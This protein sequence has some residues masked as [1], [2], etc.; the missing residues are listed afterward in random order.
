MDRIKFYFYYLDSQFEGFAPIIRITVFVVMLLLFLYLLS[1][2]RLFLI[3]R[4]ISKRRRRRK[5]IRNKYENGIRDVICSRVNLDA[6]DISN[7]IN[8]HKSDNKHKWQKEMFTKLLLSIKEKDREKINLNNYNEILYLLRLENYWE[9][10]ISTGRTGRKIRGIRK[11]EE[12]TTEVVSGIV[13]PLLYHRNENLRKLARSEFIK[14]EEQDAFRFLEE[15][16]FDR[17]FNRLDE[18]RLHSSIKQKSQEQALPLLA[19]WVQNAQNID[20]KCFLI[21]EIAYFKQEES[22][23]Y[24]L[25]IF[26][27]SRDSSVQAEIVKALG[28]LQYEGAL[29]VFTSQFKLYK[30]SIQYNIVDAIG[31]IGKEESLPFLFD[32]YDDAYNNEMKLKVLEAIQ[33]C[34]DKD[35]ILLDQR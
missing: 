20:F 6:E 14:F 22:A 10:E 15:E 33:K 19:Q 29:P 25:E 27:G 12:L 30:L 31:R 4:G 8:L 13:A 21:R 28:I 11:I 17:K 34:R 7:R 1:L 18:I 35:N 2:S 32:I 9:N 24:L 16:D 23:P 3:N 5:E 26:K